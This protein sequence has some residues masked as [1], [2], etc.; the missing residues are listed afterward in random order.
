VAIK[1]ALIAV[2]VPVMLRYARINRPR[3]FDPENV[4]AD[5][6]PPA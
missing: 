4:P 5:V 2:Y 6:L 1:L 3:R